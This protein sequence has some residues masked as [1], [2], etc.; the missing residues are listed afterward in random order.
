[1]RFVICSEFYSIRSTLEKLR[2][3]EIRPWRSL[4]LF[5]AQPRNRTSDAPLQLAP[6]GSLP[7]DGQ[8]RAIRI[9]FLAEPVPVCTNESCGAARRGPCVVTA[10][11]VPA[12]HMLMAKVAGAIDT[13]YIARNGSHCL[14]LLCTPGRNR[15]KCA[16]WVAFSS[17][18]DLNHQV[19]NRAL[20]VGHWEDLIYH[21]VTFQ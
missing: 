12:V 5:L 10:E 9:I 19:P 7:A 14:G 18:A 6:I 4:G 1:M 15:R 21:T 11:I 2:T 17:R 3:D 8:W 20:L 16:S 13:V